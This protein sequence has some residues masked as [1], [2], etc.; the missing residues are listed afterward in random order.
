MPKI[1]ES[2]L[3][4]VLTCFSLFI[5]FIFR[6]PKLEAMKRL[7]SYTTYFVTRHPFERL[8][9]AHSSKFT[10]RSIKN[11]YREGIGKRVAINYADKFIN[12]LNYVE[13]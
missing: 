2:I 5:N 4:V 3:Q 6:L 9:S 10:N 11:R 1:G 7:A 8:V 12:G 13:R